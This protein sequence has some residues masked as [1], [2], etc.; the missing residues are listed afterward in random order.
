MAHALLSHSASPDGVGWLGRTPPH[1]AVESQFVDNSSGHY[2]SMARTVVY[3]IVPPTLHW[4]WQK[5]AIIPLWSILLARPHRPRAVGMTLDYIVSG[6]QSVQALVE[7]VAINNESD[8]SCTPKIELLMDRLCSY[9]TSV[10]C[11]EM[12]QPS[13]VRFSDVIGELSVTSTDKDKH[14]I[15]CDQFEDE[16]TSPTVLQQCLHSMHE[17]TFVNAC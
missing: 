14:R 4:S 2:L 12:V 1:W 15:S 11:R 5:D 13:N 16:F 8:F 9:T 7:T 3:A 17:T 10:Q 6:E